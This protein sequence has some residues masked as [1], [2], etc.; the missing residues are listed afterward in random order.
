MSA[1]SPITRRWPVAIAA[2]LSLLLT[3]GCA[4]DYVARTRQARAA[5]EQSDFTDALREL[6]AAE[7]DA[8]ERDKLL[9]LLDRGMYQHAAG[10]HQGSIKTLAEADR[11]SQQLDVVS[12]T[13]EAGVLLSNERNKHYRGEDFEK[14]MISVLQAL[15]YAQLGKEEDAL[16]EVRRV[17]ERLQVLV[18]EGRPYEQLAVARY[19]GG[20]L[21]EDQGELD[22]AIIDYQKA[23]ELEPNLGPLA[24]PLLRLAKQTGRED[25]HALLRARFPTLSDAPLGPDEGEVLVVI[26]AGRAPEKQSVQ[27]NGEIE[28]I[29]IP[30]FR[31]R[32]SGAPGV[33]E[34]SGQKQVATRVTNLESVAKV[35]LD[36]RVGRMIAKQFAGAAVKAGIAVGAAALT[37]SESV[38][39]LAYL[40]LSMGNA[41]DLR[42][43]LS[44]P[45]EFQ[46]AR[47]RLPAGKHSVRVSSGGVSTTHEVEIRPRRLELLVLRRF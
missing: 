25:L 8:P 14:L 38:G 45:A 12:I 21:W 35:H 1:P 6:E 36:D 43:W 39:V 46:L 37:R 28:H 41:P 5:Y 47:V 10:D 23:F 34:V 30:V 24:E 9:L 32:W 16:V 18:A 33:V 4:T 29:A 22:S 31:D 20:A 19:L 3:S 13:E 2:S 26:E 15:N 40:L 44:L 17:N 7:K 27:R 11:L 42:S